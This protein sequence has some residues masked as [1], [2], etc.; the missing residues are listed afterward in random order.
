MK[1]PYAVLGVPRGASADEVKRAFRK[2]AKAHH[3]DRNHDDP[4][5][6]ERFNAVNTAYEIL[7]A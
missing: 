5:A 1:D 3:P 6:K 2:L 7:G 4:S